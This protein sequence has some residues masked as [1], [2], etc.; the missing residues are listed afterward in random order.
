[1]MG[2]VRSVNLEPTSK[3][4]LIL[5]NLEAVC[6]G[7][8]VTGEGDAGRSCERISMVMNRR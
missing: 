2:V 4:V 1:M 3:L 7:I 5:E 8:L 6:N